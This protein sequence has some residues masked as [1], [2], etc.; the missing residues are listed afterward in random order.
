MKSV[1]LTHLSIVLLLLCN[2]SILLCVSNTK[3]IERYG[4]L[5]VVRRQV[6]FILSPHLCFVIFF[7]PIFFI[8]RALNVPQK[9]KFHNGEI[10]WILLIF[11]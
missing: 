5:Y 3:F 7:I 11:P 4:S 10:V 9:I 6:R 2:S 1:H 8:L